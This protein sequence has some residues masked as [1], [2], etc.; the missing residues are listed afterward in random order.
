MSIEGFSD[1]STDT[2]SKAQKLINKRAFT[3][4]ALNSLKTRITSN[5]KKQGKALQNTFSLFTITYYF[6]F[7]K[8]FFSEE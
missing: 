6:Q 5:K 2:C 1:I 7:P 3:F 4:T 8:A